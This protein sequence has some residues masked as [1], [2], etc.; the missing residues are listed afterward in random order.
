LSAQGANVVIGDVDQSGGE[1]AARRIS[2]SGREALFCK[3]D[4]SRR[5]DARALIDATVTKFGCLGI[6]INNAGLQHI[7]P[8]HEFDEDRWDYL[9]GVMLT[10]TFLSTK[11]A[12]P[13][14]MAQKRGRIIN[15]NSIHGLVASEFKSAYV[16]AKH[17]IIGFT[18][19]LA[20]EDAPYNVTT[21]AICQSYVRTPI[22]EKQIAALAERHGIPAEEV[23]I[24]NMLAPAP[25][26]RLLDPKDV[27]ALV[28]YSCSTAAETITGAA[29]PIDCGWTAK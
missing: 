14:M 26:K 29:I 7:S 16:A 3:T 25:L 2:A 20:L 24:K 21:V 10:G 17:G 12:L 4:L 8:I 1:A 9:I 5:A 19:V 15:I 11:Y 22:V 28:V 27:A 23:P 13:H 6:L 18:K